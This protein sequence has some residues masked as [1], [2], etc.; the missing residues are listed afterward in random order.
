LA[1]GR[2]HRDPSA[3]LLL[4]RRDE[5]RSGFCRWLLVDL[6]GELDTPRM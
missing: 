2:V 6:F 5:K 1:A 3:A 4:S